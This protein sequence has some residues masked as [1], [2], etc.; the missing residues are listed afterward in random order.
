MTDTPNFRDLSGLTALL[1]A[2]L[3]IF[4]AIAAAS[5]WSGSL[6]IELLQRAASGAAV[7]ET[8]TAANDLRQGL[9]GGLYL[10]VYVVT[11]VVFSRWTYLSNQNAR[12]LGASGMQ[13]H[14][15]LGRWLVLRSHCNT[16]E[17]IPSTEGNLQGV[18]S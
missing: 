13:F 6:E 1:K 18:T 10:L 16:L 9:L 4:M 5:L 2:S 7:A 11:G 14:A 15:R 17:A 8:D 12:S 3:G